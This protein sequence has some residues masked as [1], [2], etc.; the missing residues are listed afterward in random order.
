VDRCWLDEHGH[1]NCGHH[2]SS[3]LSIEHERHM[4]SSVVSSSRRPPRAAT[5]AT[6][7]AP[8][9]HPQRLTAPALG[10]ETLDTQQTA[11]QHRARVFYDAALEN[12]F[13]AASITFRDLC[14]GACGSITIVC[15]QGRGADITNISEMPQTHKLVRL[16]SSSSCLHPRRVG[17]QVLILPSSIH[18]S[19][20]LAI[21]HPPVH[22][23]VSKTPLL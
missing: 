3:D 19:A 10:P 7:S 18:Y 21:T 14:F 5:I 12:S 23:P 16:S 20:R 22:N 17:V 1:E 13:G 2:A 8:D 11:R 4:R 6:T 9:V 15:S